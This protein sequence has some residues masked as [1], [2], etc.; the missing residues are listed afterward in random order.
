[1]RFCVSVNALK[2]SAKFGTFLCELFF[3]LWRGL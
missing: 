1:M 3:P 2:L